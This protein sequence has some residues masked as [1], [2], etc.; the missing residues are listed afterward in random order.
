[1]APRENSK[2]KKK[3]ERKVGYGDAADSRVNYYSY[4]GIRESPGCK[5]NE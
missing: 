1:M 4:S 3:E 5:F 2:K